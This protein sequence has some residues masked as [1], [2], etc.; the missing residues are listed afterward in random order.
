[1]GKIEA[2]LS[3]I[4]GIGCFLLMIG[5]CFGVLE[6]YVLKTTIIQGLYNI[7]ESWIYPLLIFMALAA[8]YRIGLWPRLEVFVDRMSHHPNRI[9]NIIHEVI[10]LV[11]YLAVTYFTFFYSID[12]TKDGRTFQ[13]GAANYPLWPFMWLVPLAFLVLSAEVLINLWKM[14]VKKEDLTRGKLD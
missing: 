8:S 14:I 9:I 13:A 6:R 1:M 7:I 11:M 12:L 2:V 3:E 4:G 5:V 10:G